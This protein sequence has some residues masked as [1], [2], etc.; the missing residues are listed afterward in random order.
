MEIKEIQNK[1]LSL[2]VNDRVED[3]NGLSYLS[4]SWAWTELLKIYPEATY[5]IKKF[6]ESQLPYVYDEKT[7]YM[8]FT[9]MTIQGITR[10]MWLPVMDSANK[11]MLDHTYTYKIKKWNNNTK[12][13]DY[14]EKEVQIATM[15][16]I[17]KT[18][19]R[20]LVKN[21]AMFGLGMYIYSGEDLP[22]QIEEKQEEPKETIEEKQEE[23]KK[24]EEPKKEE[25]KKE[26]YRM[27]M[28]NYCK[29]NKL[30]MNEIAVQYKLNGKS[31]DS[32][33]KK[34][35]EELKKEEQ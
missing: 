30:N 10:E 24:Q 34:V 31:K 25:P 27:M 17:N 4:W 9:T 7:G 26:D 14:I 32:E 29:K 11:A 15:F 28:I 23:Q 5:E 13:Y 19:M 18:I 1:L 2:N 3:K 6:G 16:D 8:V 21:I 20:C 33:F 12:S 22:E 35:L